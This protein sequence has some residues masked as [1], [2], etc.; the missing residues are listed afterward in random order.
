M[1]RSRAGIA[2]TGSVAREGYDSRGERG[3]EKERERCW[4]REGGKGV[5]KI[6]VGQEVG[7]GW[8]RKHS[9]A[10]EEGAR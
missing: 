8:R 3:E 9:P 10:E 2:A 4:E 1:S 7:V 6:K 5:P